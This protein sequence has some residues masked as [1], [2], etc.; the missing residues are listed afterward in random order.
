MPASRLF[1]PSCLA[2][3][4]SLAATAPLVHAQT[5][6]GASATLDYHI[7]AGP[8][9]ATLNRIA[10]DAGRTLSVGPALVRDLRAPAVEGRMSVEQA[11]EQALQG[12]GLALVTT[13]SGALTVQR[14]PA[15]GVQRV[16][17][18][19]VQGDQGN[20]TV[21]GNERLSP[22]D[23]PYASP[24]SGA[25]LSQEQ[26]E[27]FR[28]TQAGDIFKSV[29]GVLNGDN[30]NSGAVDLNIR[31]M[32]GF[33]RVPVVIDGSQQQVTVYRGYAGVAGRSYIDPDMIGGI[34]IEKGP[35]AGAE[36][37]GAIG[38]VV[39]MRTLNAE[40]IITGDKDWGI[41]LKGGFSDNSTSPPPAYTTG[42]LRNGG[43]F[44]TDC[45]GGRTCTRQPVPTTF[46]DDTGMDRP[47][48]GTPTG[49]S[50][51][52]AVAKRWDQFEVV[53]VYA[54]RKTGNY[55]AGE[56][57]PNA[58]EPVLS[59][60]RTTDS[61]GRWVEYTTVNFEGLNRFR[62]G[63]EVLNT[64]VDNQSWLLKG[65]WKPTA[66]QAL[67]V[68]HMKF[69]SRYGELMPS[70]ILRGEGALQ[71]AL[72][73]VD[74]D[75]WTARYRW[76]PDNDL[77]DF[78]A[79]A[80]KTMLD[81]TI[82]NTYS[83][84]ALPPDFTYIEVTYRQA[85]RWGIDATNTSRFITGWGDMALQ[86]GLTHGK[87][88]V[89][90]I[91]ATQSFSSNNAKRQE[92]SAFLSGEW[93]PTDWLKVDAAVRHTRYRSYDRQISQVPSTTRPIIFTPTHL[94][95][96]GNGTTPIAA[97]TWTPVDGVQVY[98]RYAEAMRMPGLF[99]TSSGPVPTTRPMDLRPE[100]A[101]NR[102]YGVNLLRDGLFTGRDKARLKVAY[103]DN[104]VKDYLT[105]TTMQLDG[106][107]SAPV[108]ENIDRADFKG[109][110][111]SAEYSTPR[112][113]GELSGTY[114]TYTNFCHSG[115]AYP[116]RTEACHAGGVNDSYASN[117]IPP[118]AAGALTLGTHLFEQRLTAGTR[119]SY[120]GH[121]PMREAGASL[122]PVVDWGSY[123][124]VD[125]FANYRLNDHVAVDLTVDNL[126]DRYY[127]DA[128]TLG[129]MASPGRT[130]R[131]GFTVNF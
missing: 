35:S 34:N 51:S 36:G 76:N 22:A 124:L 6:P 7:A 30:R 94:E 26:I 98:A 103:F 104:H 31:G 111:L 47:G 73:D 53:G 61:R 70:A 114:Y 119:V 59:T 93:V 82:R 129:L 100:H 102:E 5:T 78:K 88:D 96:R 130:V 66:H 46:A 38:G 44:L 83:F 86:Y 25:Y 11:A 128:M 54:R 56:N 123:V 116:T 90:P 58:P 28:G 91:S 24:Q 50:G 21:L 15:S 89:H 16:G 113:F 17:T 12:S 65:T 107:V 125:V 39:S 106:W 85:E 9:G 64:S 4:L 10:A 101:R 8:L 118:R 69:Q 92:S 1:R 81:N 2:L 108:I 131:L 62:A 45:G 74:A 68:G 20:R 18:L 87:E 49:G 27:R 37:V 127:M 120:T 23:R 29:P 57:G 80:W 42:G 77:I 60:R 112:F 99:E 40:D 97:L 121:R 79:N 109:Y 19:R 71:S 52:L 3:A 72:S 105:R 122:I 55:F 41:R 110:E 63:E 14:A 75:T 32:Q 117:H 67:E 43:Q 115:R 84:P 33:N 95:G 48:T 126:T 13:A